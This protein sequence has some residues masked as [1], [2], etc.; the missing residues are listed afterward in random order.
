MLRLAINDHLDRSRVRDNLELWI[1]R[2]VSMSST[3]YFHM[4]N[5]QHSSD[6]L[7]TY[8]PHSKILRGWVYSNIHRM[9]IVRATKSISP[10]GG[11]SLI[12]ALPIGASAAEMGPVHFFLPKRGKSDLKSCLRL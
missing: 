3:C 4:P 7:S 1:S 10:I 6:C 11:K 8:A 12:P 2:K 9:Q 5:R